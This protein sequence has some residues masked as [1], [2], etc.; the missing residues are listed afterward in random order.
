M[1]WR[2]KKKYTTHCVGRL[3]VAGLPCQLE[4]D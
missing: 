1:F 2:V 3:R 4:N